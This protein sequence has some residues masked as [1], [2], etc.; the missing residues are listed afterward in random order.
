MK[1]IIA[2]SLVT[3]T[4]TTSVT[5]SNM[6]GDFGSIVPKVTQ[7]SGFDLS[8]SGNA[9]VDSATKYF[10]TQSSSLLKK[11]TSKA[12][13]SLAAYAGGALK[14]ATGNTLDYCYTYKPKKSGDFSFSLNPCDLFKGANPCKLAP[15]LSSMGFYKKPLDA[16]KDFEFIKNLCDIGKVGVDEKK[17]AAMVQAYSDDDIL[18]QDTQK[19]KKQAEG[20]EQGTAKA[21]TKEEAREELDKLLAIEQLQKNKIIRDVMQGN[22]YK[23]AVVI[24]NIIKSS[25]TKSLDGDTSNLDLSNFNVK[26]AT[27][28]E[29]EESIDKI[30]AQ[31][32]STEKPIN[33][34]Y[35]IRMAIKEFDTINNSTTDE[36]ERR[37]Q[38]E[39]S[40]QNLLKTLKESLSLKEAM[41]IS[42][43]DYKVDEKTQI[44]Y[45]T[46][47]YVGRGT[48][49]Q[50]RLKL[51]Y[52][53]TKQKMLKA[54]AI[55]AIKSSHETIYSDVENA[56]EAAK[57][58]S[59]LF[60]R[61]AA[62]ASLKAELGL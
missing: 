16:T 31:I 9:L 58:N 52:H 10:D 27:L 30:S 43:L 29:Y 55:A 4:F 53:I 6:F 11:A 50:D 36:N 59:E 14:G 17:I 44:A 56:I 45:P 18:A 32:T 28:K 1:R 37:E 24:K 25:D 34:S 13:S 51:A 26:D 57:I 61:Q 22:D 33:I 38:K 3:L 5:A 46:K 8:G 40:K 42:R 62:L 2:I 12:T 54:E 35:I 41:E 23:S 39:A 60:N 21:K 15:D 47:E 48:T 20:A 49:P 7:G 19:N